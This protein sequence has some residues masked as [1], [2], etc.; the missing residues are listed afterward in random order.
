MGDD[1]IS[2]FCYIYNMMC[3]KNIWLFADTHFGC[4]GD[5]EIWLNDYVSYF[6]NVVFP[7]MRKNVKSEDILVHCGDV[8]DCRSTIGLNTM[9]EVIS[10]FEELSDIF[11]DIRIIIGNHDIFKKS[12]NDITSVNCLKHIKNVKIYYKPKL[13]II[14]DKKIL[15]N[16]WIE[17]PEEQKNV[18]KNVNADYIFGHFEI[19]G[20]KT[21]RNGIRLDSSKGVSLSDFKNSQVYAGHI[22]IRQDMKNIHYVG[23]PYHKDKG[24][25][26]NNKGFT[27]L[28]VKT[29]E[30]MFIENKY[31][32]IFI[33]ESIYDILDDTIEDLK[34]RWKNNY[35]DLEVLGSDITTCNF[36]GLRNCLTGYYKEFNTVSNRNQMISSSVSESDF[37]EVKSSGDYM[38]DF[39]D[40]QDMSPAFREEVEKELKTLIEGV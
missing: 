33:K 24:D 8:F 11:N 32:P 40:Q 16:P 35:I 7:F 38:N 23:N 4:K 15:F 26:E 29:G 20:A 1:N 22:H 21:N 14:D 13:E 28:D 12:T 27:I 6:R 37:E 30:G 18:L 31:S 5:N 10:L 34:K 2:H 9:C 39:L 36:D 25:L 3:N 19:G 17:N